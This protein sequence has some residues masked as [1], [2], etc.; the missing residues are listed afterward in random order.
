MKHSTFIIGVDVASNK[1]NID[2]HKDNH[3]EVKSFVVNYS[4]SQL[5]NMIYLV[6][7]LV[8][9]KNTTV[10]MEATGHY[11]RIVFY[12]FHNA[13]FRVVLVNPIKT[14]S[15]HKVISNRKTKTDKI[16]AHTI[17]LF[18]AACL[19]KP[20]TNP[21]PTIELKNLCR[22]Y[23]TI[24]DDCSAYQRRLRTTIDQIFPFFLQLFSDP[25]SKTALNILKEYPTPQ[26]ILAENIDT[27][28]TKIK[29]LARKSNKW[30]TDKAL[31]LK[32]SA[33]DSPYVEKGAQSN[34]FKLNLYIDIIE[35]LQ[36][37][38]TSLKKKIENI[39]KDIHQYHWLLTIPSVGPITAA[40]VIS[41]IG[42]F[43]VFSN[44]KQLV[45]FAGIDPSVKQSGKFKGSKNKMSKRGSKYL[46]RVIYMI[47]ISSIRKKRNGKYP[48][49]ILRKYYELKLNQGKK[50]KVAIGACMTKVIFYIYATLRNQKPFVLQQPI[51]YNQK[52]AA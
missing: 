26:T 4:H 50:P 14:E 46:R 13:G 1:C 27:L 24:L 32:K 45:A 33:S 38:L 9:R 5:N 19:L 17:A 28:T 40:T 21:E 51:T 52:L 25:F 18:Y 31:Y 29:L 43:S 35:T 3:Q 22:T 39:A 37:K 15:F 47:A 12:R 44:P 10:V 41:E 7:K 34:I 49:P 42:D 6:N 11:H 2:I 16:D 36:Q 20:I 23:F 48:N 30:A 8:D